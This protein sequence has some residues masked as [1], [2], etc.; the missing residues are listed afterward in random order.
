MKKYIIILA[1]LPVLCFGQSDQV[2]SL[3]KEIESLKKELGKLKSTINA[4]NDEITRL[5][6]LCRKHNIDPEDKLINENQHESDKSIFGIHL[7]EKIEDLKKRHGLSLLQKSDDFQPIYQV[8]SK[9]DSVKNLTVSTYNDQVGCISIVF[10]DAST[11]NLKAIIEKLENTYSTELEE[12]QTVNPTYICLTTIG[13][14]EIYIRIQLEENFSDDNKL[15][16]SYLD[17][18]LFN[19]YQEEL[20]NQKASKIADEL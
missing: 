17:T 2:D 3:K 8:D 11:S 10:K 18:A 5:K 19:Q 20:K 15:T 7:G 14:K 6:L 13:S 1:L 9:D 4:N 16:L 12:K